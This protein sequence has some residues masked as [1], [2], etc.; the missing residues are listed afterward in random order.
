V[1][2]GHQALPPLGYG[3]DKPCFPTCDVRFPPLADVR[4]S[5]FLPVGDIRARRS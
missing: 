3:D 5:R 2:H 4:N 1:H